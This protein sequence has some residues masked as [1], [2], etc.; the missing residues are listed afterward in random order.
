MTDGR[1][2][3]AGKNGNEVAKY[4]K[5]RGLPGFRET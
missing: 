5:F 2:T 1:I 4:M 3:V